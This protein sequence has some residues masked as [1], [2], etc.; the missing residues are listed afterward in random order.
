MNE[1]DEP[2]HVAGAANS[3][4]AMLKGPAPVANV[5]LVLVIAFHCRKALLREGCEP[6]Y[7]FLGRFREGV[8]ETLRESDMLASALEVR[9]STN[10]AA[11]LKEENMFIG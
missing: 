11:G 9:C 1:V 6:V 3:P 5:A 7:V 4:P 8:F 2:I 10:I